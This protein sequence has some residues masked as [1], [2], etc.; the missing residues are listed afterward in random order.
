VIDDDADLRSSPATSSFGDLVADLG[1]FA[2]RAR[3]AV[4][5]SAVRSTKVTPDTG[6]LPSNVRT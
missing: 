6:R 2:G 4:N 3:S 1:G 5:A